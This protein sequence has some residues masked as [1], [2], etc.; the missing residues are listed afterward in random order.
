MDNYD[1]W[2][3]GDYKMDEINSAIA[4]QEAKSSEFQNNQ[5]AAS[6]EGTGEPINMVTFR[7]LGFTIPK[8][9]SI[10]EQN[11]PQPGGTKQIWS[12]AMVV[13][14]KTTAV[15]AYREV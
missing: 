14:G 15:I 11:D 7:K 10:V 3:P 1:R 5:V 12:G 8:P 9:L 6:I 13:G 4:F 2:M